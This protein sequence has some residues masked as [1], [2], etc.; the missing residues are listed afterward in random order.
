METIKLTV[1]KDGYYEDG[2]TV[3]ILKLSDTIYKVAYYI[4]CEGHHVEY[5]QCSTYMEAL[6][7]Y[8][9]ICITYC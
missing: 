9:E 7:D 5:S 3:K 1:L 8:E 2:L 6:N 4:H